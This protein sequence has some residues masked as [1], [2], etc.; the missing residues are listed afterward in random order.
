[1]RFVFVGAGN[2]TVRTAHLLIEKGH[3]VVIIEADLERIDQLSEELDCSFLHGDGSK[4][5]VLEEADPAQS[6]VLFALS[7][8]EQD[9]IVAALVARS[10]GFDR[11][12]PRITEPKFEY[13]CEELGLEDV[14]DPDNTISHYLADMAQGI[15]VLNL[16][17]AI[18]GDARLF[19]WILA[20]RDV[21]K[22]DGLDLPEQARVICFYRQSVF[23]LADGETQLEKGDEVVVITHRDNLKTLKKRW[24][25]SE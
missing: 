20:A 17:T 22:V 15:D 24:H 21:G 7:D 2:L 23:H 5:Q 16:A 3:E 10:Q 6:E 12:V 4:P 25:P 9:N 11:V 19:S 1:M 18:R 13:I 14:I 8:N